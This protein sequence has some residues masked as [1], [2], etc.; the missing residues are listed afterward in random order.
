M[1]L[2][3]VGLGIGKVS[4]KRQNKTL[5]GGKAWQRRRLAERGR[6]STE[7]EA[8]EGTAH[9]QPKHARTVFGVGYTQKYFLP[10]PTHVLSCPSCS[11]NLCHTG[12]FPTPQT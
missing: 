5:Q 7:T 4:D 3:K 12:L 11:V 10:A 6:P 1:G 9:R 2:V 8:K